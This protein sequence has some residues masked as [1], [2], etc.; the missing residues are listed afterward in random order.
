MNP[1]KR[2]ASHFIFLWIAIPLLIYIS[3]I[4][5]GR[6]DVSIVHF[7]EILCIDYAKGNYTVTALYDNA[8]SK[9]DDGLKLID[10]KGDSVYTAYIDMTRKN[11][12]DIS[13]DHTAYFMIGQNAAANSLSECFDFIEREPDM[14]TNAHVFIVQSK[15]TN[16]LLKEAMKDDFS[17]SETLNAISEKASN[18]L[19][20]PNNTLLQVLNDV[21]HQYNN[22]L[23]PYLVYKDKNM[24][25]EGYATFRNQKLYGYLDYTT[26]QATDLFRNNLR[27]CPLELSRNLNVQLTNLDVSSSVKLKANAFNVHINL[28]TDSTIMEVSDAV[29]VFQQNILSEINQMEKYKLMELLRSIML[30]SKQEHLDLLDIGTILEKQTGKTLLEDNWETYI[31]NLDISLSVKSTT[32]K[33]YTIQTNNKMKNGT[34]QNGKVVKK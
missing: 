20:K 12:R 3:Y 6:S 29:D 8:G 19:K 16:K 14:K 4:K 1:R 21:D 2:K 27:T 5:I 13:L 24:Y 32:A 18:N 34:I 11:S 15:N 25:L 23:I 30:L 17:P 10:G 9:T 33:T 26:S 31:E 22:L 7:V 28:K